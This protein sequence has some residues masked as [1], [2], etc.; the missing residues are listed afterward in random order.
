MFRDFVN[1]EVERYHILGKKVNML[2]KVARVN[3]K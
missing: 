2:E 3:I 1:E